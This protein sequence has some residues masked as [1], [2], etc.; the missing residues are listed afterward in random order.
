MLCFD[1]V[2][3]NIILRKN[4]LSSPYDRVF[5]VSAYGGVTNELLEYKK[6]KQA[7]IYTYFAQGQDYKKYMDVLL[8]KLKGINKKL[9]SLGL[10]LNQANEFIEKRFEQSKV[11]LENMKGV[12]SSGYILKERLLLVS[13]EILAS[14]GETHSAFNTVNII[15]NCGFKSIFVDLSGA[16]DSRALSINERIEESVKDLKIDQCI[17]VLTGYTKGAEGIMREFD[18]GYSEVTFSKVATILKA[19]EAIIHKEYHL[20]SADPNI[21]GEKNSIPVCFTNFDVADQLADLGMEAIHPKASKPL[22]LAGIKIRVKNTFDP[23]HSGTLITKDYLNEDSQVEIIAGTNEVSVLEIHDSL[24]VGQFG[25]DYGILEV[26]KRYS[27]NYLLK[28]SNANTITH[29]LV[30]KDM[31]DQVFLEEL[32]K[33]YDSVMVKK[34]AIVCAIGS[35]IAKPGILQKATGALAKAN[36]N[37]N[38]LSQTLRQVNIQFVIERKDYQKAVKVLNESLCLKR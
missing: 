36:I 23:M 38:C 19:T 29:L 10:D 22:E 11:Y 31:Q 30:D 18:R 28:A 27:K 16:Y 24:M 17:P 37:V 35:N 21:V 12:L 33:K 32:K 8:K 5:V 34:V 14:I 20:S 6:N 3:S 7:G 1:E 25:F 2:L 13:R 26:F 15:Q 4:K 9:V